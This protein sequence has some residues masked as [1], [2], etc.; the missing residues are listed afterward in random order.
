MHIQ[1]QPWR[2]LNKWLQKNVSNL[3]IWVKKIVREPSCWVINFQFPKKFLEDYIKNVSCVNPIFPGT[4]F[5]EWPNYYM[6]YIFWRWAKILFSRIGAKNFTQSC[7]SVIIICY[8]SSLIFA[9]MRCIFFGPLRDTFL[10]DK[11]LP[12]FLKNI[13][14]H[15]HL[16]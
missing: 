10:A 12:Q 7:P 4:K 15:W 1:N 11:N 16:Y 5:P 3:K 9:P 13:K 14:R 6:A 2:G 8:E